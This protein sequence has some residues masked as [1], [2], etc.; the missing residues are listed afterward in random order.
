MVHKTYIVHKIDL[1][2]DQN[3]NYLLGKSSESLLSNPMFLCNI[4]MALHDLCHVSSKQKHQWIMDFVE[5]WKHH[6]FCDQSLGLG[7][8]STL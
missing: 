3:E 4:N 8:L 2:V 7:S 1:Y 5:T 6:G